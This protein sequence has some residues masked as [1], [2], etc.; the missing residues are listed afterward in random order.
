[1]RG[2]IYYFNIYL[3]ILIILFSSLALADSNFDKLDKSKFRGDL[4]DDIKNKK[5]KGSTSP[6]FERILVIS[7][8]NKEYTKAKFDQDK[9]IL[10]KLSEFVGE[11]KATFIGQNGILTAINYNLND[12][13]ILQKISNDPDV[14]SIR[15]DIIYLLRDDAV[16]IINSDIVNNMT[17]NGENITG[18]GQ[19]ICLVDT[20]VD[21]N[22]TE[23]KNYTI[24][25]HDYIDGDEYPMDTAGHGTH[26]AGILHATA[27]EAKIVAVRFC[28]DGNDCSIF[29]LQK[30]VNWCLNHLAEYNI[31]T[32]SL[33]VGDGGQHTSNGTN[34]T[35]W[36]PIYLDDEFQ[37]ALSHDMFIASGSGNEGFTKGINY[38]GCS[39]YSTAVGATTKTDVMASY[40]NT[41]PTLLDFLAPGSSISSTNDG[42]GYTTMHGTSMATPFVAAAGVLLRQNY[43]LH[44]L[45]A[46][47][48]LIKDALVKTGVSIPDGSH[49]WPRIDVAAAIN[50]IT[51]YRDSDC[52]NNSYTQE[53]CG[54]DENVYKNL[55]AHTCVK[56]GSVDNDACSVN[57]SPVLIEDCPDTC[58]NGTCDPV[59]CFDESDCGTDAWVGADYCNNSDKYH[60][61]LNYTCNNPGLSSS[62]CSNE[63]VSLL[64]ESCSYGCDQGVCV[65]CS[66]NS[67]CGT[68]FYSGLYCNNEDV[69]T[70]FTQYTCSNPGNANATCT[71]TSTPEL[72]QSCS[73]GCDQGV[74]VACSVDGDCGTDFYSGLYC[75]N[76][77]IY[78]NF[79]QYTCSNP[80]T[81]NAN[82]SSSTTPELNQT[83]PDT[84]TNGTCDPV[85]CFD[86][87]DC[88]VD[89]YT[90]NYCIE[91]DIY[92]DYIDYTCSNPGLSISYCSNTTQPILNQTCAY[93]CSSGQCMICYKDSD[94]GTDD[95]IGDR[96]CSGNDV[97]QIYRNYVCLNPGTNISQCNHSENEITRDTCTNSCINGTCDD[98]ECYSDSDCGK[99]NFIGN[100]YCNDGDVWQTYR[101]YG[102]TNPGTSSSSC[103]YSEEDKER[104]ECEYGCEQG[105]CIENPDS[106]YTCSSDSDCG[107][108]NFVGNSWCVDSSVYQKYRTYTCINPSTFSSYC[109]YSDS[110]QLKQE[111]TVNCIDGS[112]IV[113][114]C[115]I[116]SDCGIDTW[117]GPTYCNSTDVYQQYRN[118]S[119]I[120]STCS[121]TEN[122]ILKQSCAFNCSA[123]VCI[124]ENGSGSGN[125][126]LKIS[127]FV[128]QHP[129]NPTAGNPVT[130]AFNLENT[131]N[132]T[133]NNTEWKLSPGNGVAIIGF[134]SKLSPG[135]RMIIVRKVT[136]AESGTYYSKA[137]ADPRNNIYEFD[138]ANNQKEIIVNVN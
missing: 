98:I 102:C 75:N 17:V 28:D 30:G 124:D 91:D 39:P 48:S 55:T 71:N 76:D 74:C 135:N 50:N 15:K 29:K 43:E 45:S 97:K 111:C 134:I 73:Y 131:G 129:E 127:Y 109:S 86:E 16:K 34:G 57:I 107:E 37:T 99:N 51:C 6:D 4:L 36:C 88:G 33:S 125:A 65:A 3:I 85:E 104:K 130:F 92:N 115:S 60:D 116:E 32:I 101:K 66:S 10:N 27:P 112:C 82:C 78:T 38:P 133:L 120:N 79:T 137:I 114:T 100:R 14:M 95:Y 83:C 87:S 106:N 103:S 105:I 47:M 40:T 122:A 77:D 21:Y 20:G 42:G 70:N 69:Y 2:K 63:T 72:N 26:I 93:Q 96:Y 18:K 128:L 64:N 53:Y 117:F 89:G 138:E 13:E 132:T 46:N 41:H 31:T 5:V 54:A 35:T 56:P 44:N 58:T 59:E 7:K 1:M 25:G 22:H 61:Y 84:C 94:C 62:Y 8:Q 81:I 118:W 24:L 119:C 19:S 67:D 12:L 23:L 136:Y 68:D 80:G 11:P 52:G 9:G 113:D 121:Y 126:D 90:A 108:N 123:G 110:I 49:N